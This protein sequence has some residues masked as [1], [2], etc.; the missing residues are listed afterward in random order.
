MRDVDLRVYRAEG[1]KTWKEWVQEV[2]E[3]AAIVMDGTNLLE[4]STWAGEG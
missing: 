1:P 3:T 2:K 4:K